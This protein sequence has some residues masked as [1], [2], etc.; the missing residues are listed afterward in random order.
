[1]RGGTALKK[2]HCAIYNGKEIVFEEY[3]SYN[4][5]G[6]RLIYDMESGQQKNMAVE[7]LDRYGAFPNEVRSL[8]KIRAVE[9]LIVNLKEKANEYEHLADKINTAIVAYC[10]TGC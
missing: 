8:S 3:N 7:D 5:L 4:T 9:I 2:L 10:K 6:T 1:M